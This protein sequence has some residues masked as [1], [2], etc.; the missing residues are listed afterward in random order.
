MFWTPVFIRPESDRYLA[1]SNKQPHR[2][3]GGLTDED[4]YK[5]MLMLLA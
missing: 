2:C 5:K 3:F 1:V 4:A